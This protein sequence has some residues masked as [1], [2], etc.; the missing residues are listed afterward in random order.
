[1]IFFAF[2]LPTANGEDKATAHHPRDLTILQTAHLFQM[3]RLTNP[4]KEQISTV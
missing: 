1:M 4:F 3:Y 2:D